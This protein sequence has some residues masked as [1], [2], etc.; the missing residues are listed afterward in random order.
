MVALPVL[1]LKYP[2]ELFNGFYSCSFIILTKK[3]MA[4]PKAAMIQKDQRKPIDWAMKPT[5]GGMAKN[6]K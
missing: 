3:I 1:I 4:A 6:P 5:L 2:P